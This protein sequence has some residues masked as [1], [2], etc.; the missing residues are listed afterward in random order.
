MRLPTRVRNY[1]LLV[2]IGYLVFVIYGSLVPLNFRPMSWSS[3]LDAFD[4][5]RLDLGSG[6]RIDSATN[7]LLTIP[8]AFLWSGVVWP[9]RS[10]AW[11]L[12]A[13]V[14]VFTG[15]FTISIVVEFAQIFF[16][17]RT[18]SLNDIAAQ[19]LGEVIGITL[20]VIFGTHVMRWVETL[21]FARSRVEIA[22]RLLVLYLFVLLGYNVLPLDLSINPVEI[23]HKW[24]AGRVVILPFSWG[25][26]DRAQQL[27]ELVT[28]VA[29]WIPVAFL[30]RLSSEKSNAAVWTRAVAAA[31]L[32]EFL[33]LFVMSR[34]SDSTDLVLAGVGAALG[35]WAAHI[36]KQLD[37]APETTASGRTGRAPGRIVPWA[38]AAFVWLVIL[39]IVF[40]YP[41]NFNFESAFLRQ[42]VLGVKQ[43]PLH[44]YWASSPFRAVTEV[45]HKTG[46]LF[47]LGVLLGGIAIGIPRIVPRG[48]VHTG[49]VLFIMGTASTIEAVQIAL[50]RK[51][52]DLT[53]WF[54]EISGA[55]AGY[56]VFAVVYSRLRRSRSS[57]GDVAP[58]TS[59]R[60]RGV[61]ASSRSR[62]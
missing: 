39:A 20:W 49:M 59:S 14:A 6:S 54:L 32:I 53:D 56:V 37:R 27:Y 48:L 24:N 22:Q 1:L 16:P 41:F 33:Q 60:R 46:F 36:F 13:V 12:L 28:D 8:L 18:T 62:G 40:W 58:G 31:A 50:P 44:A 30:W 55:V 15:C 29:I 2:A 7:V 51:N 61:R 34:V 3:A 9:T 35:I 25:Y 23:Y 4:A 52:V 17:G 42:R 38:A 21:P 45:L 11:R 43:V 57:S 26:T 19:G 47:P 5:L 10:P